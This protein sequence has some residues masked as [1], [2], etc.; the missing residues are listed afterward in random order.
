MTR[1]PKDKVT[2]LIL[3]G[4]IGIIEKNNR[5]S[6]RVSHVAPVNPFGHVHF[7]FPFTN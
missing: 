5:F 3:I 1:I 4:I 6:I 2:P 7:D